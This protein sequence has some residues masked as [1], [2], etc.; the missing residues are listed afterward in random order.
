[1]DSCTLH[2][3]LNLR[4]TILLRGG[5]RPA[6]VTLANLVA[7]AFFPVFILKLST[8]DCEHEHYSKIKQGPVSCVDSI[9]LPREVSL[10]GLPEFWKCMSLKGRK[11]SHGLLN[12]VYSCILNLVLELNLVY[13]CILNL[14]YS[15]IL[16]LSAHTKGLKN[17]RLPMNVSVACP[18]VELREHTKFSTKFSIHFD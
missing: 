15:C 5:A 3:I 13:S 8:I 12:L 9:G 16:K 7:F 18:R 11:S 14:V 17:F 6:T 4:S 1:M 2:N 10:R